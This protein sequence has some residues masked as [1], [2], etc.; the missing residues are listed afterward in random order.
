[1]R[2]QFSTSHRLHLLSLNI[3][4]LCGEKSEWF[5]I[6]PL[7]HFKDF[8]P[9]SFS[10]VQHILLQH[11]LGYLFLTDNKYSET[12]WIAHFTSLPKKTNITL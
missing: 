4:K 2:D 7:D 10:T 9:T 12:C 8:G 5:F 3:V 6:F 11:R 1:M